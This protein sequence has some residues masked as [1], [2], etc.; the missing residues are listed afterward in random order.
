MPT[1]AETLS[2]FRNPLVQ[3]RKKMKP[4]L[5]QRCG[6]D[7]TVSPDSRTPRSVGGT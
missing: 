3:P 4:E 1:V 5:T 2:R 6:P 7:I